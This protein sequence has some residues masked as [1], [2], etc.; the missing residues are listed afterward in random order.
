MIFL[1]LGSAI[2]ARKE[3]WTLVKRIAQKMVKSQRDDP[4]VLK[5]F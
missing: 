4:S 1:P 2:F 5:V 3:R